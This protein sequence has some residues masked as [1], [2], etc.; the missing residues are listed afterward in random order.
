VK[1]ECVELRRV[2][3]PMRTPFRTSFGI[4]GDRDILV[5][6][7]VTADGEGWGECPALPEPV[8]SAEYVDGAHDVLRRFLVPALLHLDDVSA[9]SAG[10]AWARFH[11]H[12][13]AKGALETAVLTAE[14]AAR[15]QSLADFLGAT[16]STVDCGISV[17]IVDDIDELLDVVTEFLAE[18]YVRVKLKIEPGWDVEPVAAV[19]ACFG[20]DLLL[21]VDANAAY[22][23]ADARRLARL[24]EYDLLLMEQPFP[25]M[26]VRAH[27]ELARLV[28]TPICLD[29]SIVSAEVA[30]DALALGAC[31][32]VNIKAPRVGGFLEARRVHD[33]CRANGVPVWCGGMIESGIGRAA[34]LALAALPGFV[35]PGDIAS[36]SRFFAT[37]LLRTPLEMVDGCMRVPDGP[38]LGVD[39]DADALEEMTVSMETIGR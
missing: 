3:L 8:Y 7:V 17:G 31:R 25:E 4:V 6:R 9:A 36:S 5:V 30:A 21:Q 10:R 37:D 27:A 35:L 29:E 39:V 15:G 11:G 28:R 1:V 34:N 2:S 22:R 26:Q 14:L 32:I 20:D 13:M 12:H 16:R 33:L 18:G 19:R 24:D 23:L 38:G